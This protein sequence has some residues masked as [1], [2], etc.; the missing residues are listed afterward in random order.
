MG[1][2]PSLHTYLEIWVPNCWISTVSSAIRT[3]PRQGR[4]RPQSRSPVPRSVDGR[5]QSS[6]SPSC[7]APRCRVRA[8]ISK[9]V[10]PAP[11]RPAK[12]ARSGS[13]SA[14]RCCDSAKVVPSSTSHSTC[15]RAL[16][17]QRANISAGASRSVAVRAIEAASA[18]GN[19]VVGDCDGLDNRR[20][21]FQRSQTVVPRTRA[22]ELV[23]HHSA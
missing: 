1:D 15:V 23:I 7:G 12:D 18:L 2:P 4:S 14:W 16:S 10:M 8:F 17:P 22:S 19:V 3:S 6:D 5:S 11:T 13:A 21:L 9:S 20:G